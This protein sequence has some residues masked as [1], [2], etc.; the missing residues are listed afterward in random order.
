[1][2][3]TITILGITLSVCMVVFAT[4]A[5]IDKVIKNKQEKQ[6]NSQI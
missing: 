4:F 2:K 1:M 5:L 3:K 6:L